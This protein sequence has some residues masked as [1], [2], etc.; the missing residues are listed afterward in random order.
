MSDD[1][2][3]RPQIKISVKSRAQNSGSSNGAATS[4]A[5]TIENPVQ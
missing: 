2:A 4:S 5:S 1:I 3:K